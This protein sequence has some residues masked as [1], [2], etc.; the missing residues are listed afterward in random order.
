M[1]YRKLIVVSYIIPISLLLLMKL[2]D[3]VYKPIIAV[4]GIASVLT[5]VLSP[6]LFVVAIYSF[7]LSN[8]FK[9]N[10]LF[11]CLGT[12]HL[13]A[14]SIGVYKLWPQLMGI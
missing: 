11:L 3:F 8:Q 13:I 5:V 12:V 10:I 7:K 2:A 4:F 9:I 6:V 14:V 1:I